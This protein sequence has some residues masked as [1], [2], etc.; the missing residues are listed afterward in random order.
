MGSM[1]PIQAIVQALCIFNLMAWAS[2]YQFDNSMRYTLNLHYM[3]GAPDGVYRKLIGTNGDYAWNSP[4]TGIKGQ[5]LIVTVINNLDEPTTIHWHGLF[6]TN[7]SW[8]DGT[9]GTNQC[10]IPPG[11]NFTYYIDLN[12]TGTY[13]WHSH[14]KTQYVD[15][16]RGPLVILDPDE[17]Y[18]YDEDR[19]VQL[20]EWYH[21]QAYY[22]LDSFMNP[23][24]DGVEPMPDTGLINS[25]GRYNCSY[26]DTDN[27]HGLGSCF[28]Q[29]REVIPVTSSKVYRFRLINQAAFAAFNFSIDGHDMTVIEVDGVNVEPHTVDRIQVNVAQRYSV[30][31]YANQTSDLYWIRARMMDH[32]PWFAGDDPEGLNVWTYGILSYDDNSAISTTTAMTVGTQNEPTKSIIPANYTDLVETDLQPLDYYAQAPSPDIM[33]TM[34]F[35][36]DVN[37][38]DN[39]QYAYVSLDNGSWSSLSNPTE[40]VLSL[41]ANGKSVPTSANAYYVNQSGI[42]QMTIWNNDA[43]EHPFHLHGHT[44]WIMGRGNGAVPNASYFDNITNPVQ[45]DTLTI[46][47]CK[48]LSDNDTCDWNNL[49][50][51][52]IR[53]KADNVGVWIFHCHIEWHLE[54]GLGMNFVV[55]P[56]EIR[57]T[58][59]PT[60]SA[61]L[62]SA[63]S[64]AITS[65]GAQVNPSYKSVY[66]A[67]LIITWGILASMDVMLYKAPN[68]RGKPEQSMIPDS[69]HSTIFFLIFLFTIIAFLFNVFLYE[70][71]NNIGG[72]LMAHMVLEYFVFI[73]T[74]LIGVGEMYIFCSKKNAVQKARFSLYLFLCFCIVWLIAQI[75]VILLLAATE[76]SLFLIVYISLM[77]M[78][79]AFSLFRTGNVRNFMQ[80]YTLV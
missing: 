5:K 62:C 14:Y 33:G 39:I 69:F 16:L 36:F 7:A 75:A 25:Y 76:S 73:F 46:Q 70:A 77:G 11:T 9:A 24:A 57:A 55:M 80:S 72:V 12:Q 45:R 43:G 42:V 28:T 67:F 64:L 49:G 38:D 56:D 60:A 8:M 6:Q 21:D 27:Q 34:N 31:V 53:F 18:T 32:S 40:S 4:I 74:L 3:Y 78:V 54:A 63:S 59:L 20:S 22:L 65:V 26:F 1:R 61:K 50:W 66:G 15:G 23:D 19:I 47:A 10:P 17:P 68:V 44:F 79:V 37:P 41:V 58:G 35:T 48:T 29:Y 51:T 2:A 71:N 52:V 13:W 30:L